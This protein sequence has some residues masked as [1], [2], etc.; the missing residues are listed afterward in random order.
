MADANKSGPRVAWGILGTGN[1]AHQFAT[2]LIASRTGRLVAIGSRSAESAERFGCEFQVANRHASY[3]A[4]L[5]DPEVAAVYISLPNHLHSEW[6][7]RPRGGSHP[8]M[9]SERR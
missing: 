7:D 4:V 6:V 3:E 9:R 2:G 1:I 8:A 5:A